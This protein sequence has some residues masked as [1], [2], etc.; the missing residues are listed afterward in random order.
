MIS[1]LYGKRGN[2]MSDEMTDEQIENWRTMLSL[3]LGSY[4]FVMP[5]EEVQQ[6]KN[7]MQKKLNTEEFKAD[8]D[9]D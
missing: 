9:G 7:E 6:I 1:W 2:T 3:S 5:K 4:A 8:K